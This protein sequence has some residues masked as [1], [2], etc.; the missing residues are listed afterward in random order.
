MASF[1]G[2]PNFTATGTGA[3]TRP[4]ADVVDEVVYASNF[5][6]Y[7]PTGVSDSHAAIMDAVEAAKDR[8]RTLVL[9]GNPRIDDTIYLDHPVRWRMDGTH[10]LPG[11]LGGGSYIVKGDSLDGPAIVLLPPAKGSVIDGLGLLGHRAEGVPVNGGDGILVLAN[12]VV[13]RDVSVQAMGRDAVRIGGYASGDPYYAEVMAE[14]GED[15]V[16]ANLFAVENL[17][18]ALNG[19]H[20]LHISDDKGGAVDANGG[21]V[22]RPHLFANGCDGLYA[23]NTYLGSTI[24]A[25]VLEG[26]D[27]FGLHF[28]TLCNGLVVIG[29]DAEGNGAGQ[30]CE[31]TARLNR[32]VD[33]SVQGVIWDNG[34][35]VGSWTPTAFGSISPGSATYSIQRG[36][37][38]LAGGLL[39]F[40][41]ELAWTG[42]SGGS[43][44]LYVTLPPGFLL[45]TSAPADMPEMIP[46][47]VRGDV[48]S[49][50]SILSAYV[51]CAG[52]AIRVYAV[53]VS[54]GA[55]P[56]VVL[57]ASGLL[58][59]SGAYE[60]RPVVARL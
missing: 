37:F 60:V 50:G 29:G 8:H 23:N 33:L 48:A 57:P 59:I 3:A 47:S 49:S 21:L 56:N 26:N 54:T 42:H 53:N 7:D 44:S 40:H 28:D 1:T 16:N 24:V 27:G 46:C 5:T 9:Q 41:V 52:E 36:R 14:V 18:A 32:I 58:R 39:K 10:L 38:A 43:G 31:A 17:A 4:A 30:V 22:T 55:E 6:G 11:E 34:L 25:P 45:P 35:R 15:T 13:L 19:R 12:G 20:G 51:H 2:N